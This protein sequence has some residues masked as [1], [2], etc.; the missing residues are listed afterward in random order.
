MSE[1]TETAAAQVVLAEPD[2]AEARARAEELRDEK[3]FGAAEGQA[4]TVEGD[5]R[6][7]ELRERE[8]RAH[9]REQLERGAR[10]RGDA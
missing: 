2:D 8:R 10:G 3:A 7:A 9:R 1:R 4:A 6:G 5:G